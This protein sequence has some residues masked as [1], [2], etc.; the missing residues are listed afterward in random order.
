[1][2]FYKNHTGKVVVYTAVDGDNVWAT[3]NEECKWIPGTIKGWK[4]VANQFVECQIDEI[5]LV[6]GRLP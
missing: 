1:M 4:S 5:F 6:I 2:E 3:T